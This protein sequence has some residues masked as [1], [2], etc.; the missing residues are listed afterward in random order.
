MPAWISWLVVNERLEP[1]RARF[2]EDQEIR[3]CVSKVESSV[4]LGVVELS[5][6]SMRCLI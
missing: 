6:A 4:K 5:R 2:N 3:A 1:R